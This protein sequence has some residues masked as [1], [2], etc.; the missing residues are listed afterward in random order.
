MITCKL[1]VPVS[2]VCLWLGTPFRSYIM[3]SGIWLKN[4]FSKI[5]FSD[6]KNVLWS[7]G[8]TN[9]HP[10]QD[11][12]AA[13]PAQPDTAAGDTTI[14]LTSC[15]QIATWVPKLSVPAYRAAAC[16]SSPP[17]RCSCNPFCLFSNVLLL[18]SIYGLETL[19][20]SRLVHLQPPA[21]LTR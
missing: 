17:K 19:E 1:C 4:V 10:M 3:L 2:V 14:Q 18:S 11:A 13:G 20:P 5:D 9:T 21:L 12:F 16:N 8:P 7:A 6:P 15:S